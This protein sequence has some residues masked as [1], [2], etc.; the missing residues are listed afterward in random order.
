[1]PNPVATAVVYIAKEGYEAITDSQKEK[2][3]KAEAAQAKE[4]ANA[5]MEQ[6]VADWQ[7]TYGSVEQN[8][9]QYY[10]NLTPDYYLAAGLENYETEYQKAMERINTNFAQRGIDP[11]SALAMST[12]NRMEVQ[13]AK[14]RAKIRRDAPKQAADEQFKFLQL[15]LQ[16]DPVP[17]QGAF[18]QNVAGVER[19]DAYLAAEQADESWDEFWDATTSTVGNVAA[20]NQAGKTGLSK[21]VR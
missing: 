16:V 20:S 15:G 1:M 9:S 17:N 21:D 10:S 3:E 14:D 18:L 2:K 13:R 4:E 19:E 5:Q 6:Q 12:K 8:L 7:E 11:S